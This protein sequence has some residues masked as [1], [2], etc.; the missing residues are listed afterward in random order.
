LGIIC[1]LYG[2]KIYINSQGDDIV[3]KQLARI[4]ELKQLIVAAG[5]HPAQLSDIVREVI[6]ATSLATITYEQSCELIKTLEYYCDFAKRCQK[7]KL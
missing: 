7:S 1:V 5:Y 2:H 6:G 3:N 4:A